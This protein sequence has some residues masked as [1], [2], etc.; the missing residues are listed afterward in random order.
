MA[1]SNKEAI[2]FSLKNLIFR[3]DEDTG[4]SSANS[5]DSKEIRIFLQ[6]QYVGVMELPLVPEPL[7]A[8]TWLSIFPKTLRQC[9][10]SKY[11][12]YLNTQYC[13]RHY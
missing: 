10:T 11:G 1:E 6:P 5:D 12:Q 3:A 2:K 9:H 13:R 7:R 4:D 8:A